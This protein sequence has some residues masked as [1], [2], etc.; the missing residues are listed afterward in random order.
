[1]GYIEFHRTVHKGLNMHG[2]WYEVDPSNPLWIMWDAVLSVASAVG[3]G[4][5]RNRG[6]GGGHALSG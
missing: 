5:I 4:S 3:A 2:F 1:M 6:S